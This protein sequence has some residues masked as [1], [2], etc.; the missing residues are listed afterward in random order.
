MSMKNPQI[1]L[2]VLGDDVILLTGF[3]VYKQ[4]T[5]HT[6][7]PATVRMILEYLGLRVS[8]PHLAARCATHPLGTLHWTVRVGFDHFLR[9]IGYTV[10]M[11]GD[12]PEVYTRI[13]Q[14]L[15]QNLPVMF[16]FA[17]EDHFHPGKKV[18]HY[19]ALIGVDEPARTVTFA[20]PFGYIETMDIEEWWGRFSLIPEYMPADQQIAMR[21]GALKPRT[22]FRIEKMQ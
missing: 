22:V 15:K 3:P 19:G 16:I 8:E 13:K 21:I 17:V 11:E 7:G 9:K 1:P 14:S 20:N 6:C 5:D 10:K 12:P 18:T 4:E 2:P